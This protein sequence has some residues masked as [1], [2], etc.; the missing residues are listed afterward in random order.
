MSPAPRLSAVL[1]ARLHGALGWIAYK[2]GWADSARRRYERVLRLRGAEFGAY[3]QLGRIAFDQGD[4]TGWRR[5][6]EHARRTDPVRFARLR[7]PLELFEPRL[8]GT[9]L[10]RRVTGGVDADG[11]ATWT[12]IDAQSQTTQDPSS[13]EGFGHGTDTPL[14]PGYDPIAPGQPLDDSDILDLHGSAD[15]FAA[16]DPTA[17]DDEP[18]RDREPQHPIP[19]PSPP[20]ASLTRDDFSSPSERRRFRRRRPID[21][22]EIA[23]CDL[24]ELVRRL[25]G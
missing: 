19:Y 7:H 14:A 2:L 23:R 1:S 16:A 18:P 11:R 10:D 25:S 4:Y 21:S 13:S 8:A 12:P 6:L 9:N 17:S 3:V 20:D 24:A 5:A 22:G 15:P